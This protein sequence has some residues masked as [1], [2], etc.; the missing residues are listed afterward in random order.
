M[1]HCGLSSSPQSG[2]W[3]PTRTI[4]SMT[5]RIAHLRAEAYMAQNERCYYCRCKMCI[6]DPAEFARAHGISVR[7]ARQVRC[8]AEHLTARQDGGTDRRSN[9]AAACWHCNRLRHARKT[10]MP[11]D[12]YRD[13]VRRRISCG[14][15]H[16]QVFFKRLCPRPP[17]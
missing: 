11:A 3:G 10:P 15:W 6:S 17:H 5:I 8:T 12:R 1:I 16:D 4:K 9:I 7:Q 14:A 2:R 13:H